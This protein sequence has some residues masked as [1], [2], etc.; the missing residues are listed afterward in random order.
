MTISRAD[1]YLRRTRVVFTGMIN[2]TWGAKFQ[3]CGGT[4]ATRN[5][6]GG[7]YELAKSNS[8]ANSQIRLYA[9]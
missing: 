4:S 1:L 7:G 6:G 9:Q 5:L 8:K 3:T 2:E